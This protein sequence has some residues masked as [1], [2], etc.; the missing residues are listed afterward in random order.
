MFTFI[1]SVVFGFVAVSVL[2][3]TSV[4]AD[5]NLSTLKNA[6]GKVIK[7]QNYIPDDITVKS[8]A[9]VAVT[10]VAES[11]SIPAAVAGASAM[12][13][14]AGTGTAISALSGAAAVSATSAAVGAGT[15][16]AL[17]TVGIVVAPAVVGGVIIVGAGVAVGSA[18]NWLLFDD[19][20]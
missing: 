8:A 4:C 12:G 11:V 2:G 5:V 16:A 3:S 18:I 10:V 1:R 7:V 14:T 20:D 9:K 13:V 15:S 19:E 17:A 6:T